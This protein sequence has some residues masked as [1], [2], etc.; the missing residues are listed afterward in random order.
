MAE[1]AIQKIFRELTTG[2]LDFKSPISEDVSQEFGRII[3]KTLMSVIVD[4]QTY[5]LAGALD[6]TP[7]TAAPSVLTDTNP[8]DG[9]HDRD[10]QFKA[11]YL[12]FK[13]GSIYTANNLNRYKITASDATAKTLTVAEDLL[14]DG[15]ASGDTYEVIGHTHD[16]DST[17]PDGAPIDLKHL[18]NMASDQSMTQDLADAITDPSGN[19]TGSADSTKPFLTA[20]DAISETSAT[21]SNTSST[22]AISVNVAHGLGRVPVSVRIKS[23]IADG[24][25]NA[26]Y[27][28]ESQIDFSASNSDVKY[29]GWSL[30]S[31]FTDGTNWPNATLGSTTDGTFINESAVAP[32]ANTNDWYIDSVDATNIVLKC[33]SGQSSRNRYFMFTVV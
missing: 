8:T 16:G 4:D 13:S 19:R 1:N 12:H 30:S 5:L 9:G 28:N 15:A 25:N 3:A 10:D 32:Q 2:E 33:D 31:S 22:G 18:I 17:D 11:L 20:D 26:Q 27:I 29:L 23:H 24:S 6:S 21:Y 14:A 7:T